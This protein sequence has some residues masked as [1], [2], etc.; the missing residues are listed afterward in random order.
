MRRTLSLFLVLAIL[1]A[2]G[3]QSTDLGGEDDE[4]SSILGAGLVPAVGLQASGSV[5]VRNLPGFADDNLS[6]EVHIDASSFAALGIDDA[7][8]FA[9]EVVTLRAG[10]AGSPGSIGRLSFIEDLRVGGQGTI[11][12]EIEVEGGNVPGIIRRDVA[13]VDVNQVQDALVG[14]FA[15]S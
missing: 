7:D 4:G 3:C 8:G 5:V 15:G 12:F 9:D 2:A 14:Q 10:S 6:C 1:I 13:L 11:R